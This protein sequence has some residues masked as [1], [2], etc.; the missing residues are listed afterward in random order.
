MLTA[1]V[2]PVLTDTLGPAWY[3]RGFLQQSFLRPV[4]TSD[5]FCVVSAAMQGAEPGEIL[6]SLGLQKSDG[7]QA[8]G[9]LRRRRPG[10]GAGDRPLGASGQAAGPPADR[11]RGPAPG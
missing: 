3:E 4:Y 8:T 7:E 1:F 11:R 9:R 2:T 6:F 5:E 10:G